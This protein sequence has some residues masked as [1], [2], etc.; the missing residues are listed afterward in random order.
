VLEVLDKLL[1]AIFTFQ[2]AW[3]ETRHQEP[4]GTDTAKKAMPPIVAILDVFSVEK[5]AQLMASGKRAV[6]RLDN[7]MIA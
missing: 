7:G 3:R 5:D 1:G 4:R 2:I 6:L